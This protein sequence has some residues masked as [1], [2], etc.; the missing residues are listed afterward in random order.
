MVVHVDLIHQ[1][2]LLLGTKSNLPCQFGAIAQNK[3]GPMKS[4]CTYKTDDNQHF[5]YN[6]FTQ[7]KVALAAYQ[8]TYVNCTKSSSLYAANNKKQMGT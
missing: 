7:Q 2:I 6:C 8:C 5:E 3:K 4:Y 1:V